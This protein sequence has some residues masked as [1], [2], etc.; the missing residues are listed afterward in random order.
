MTTLLSS[1][2]DVGTTHDRLW[3]DLVAAVGDADAADV[4]AI[5]RGRPVITAWTAAVVHA[6]DS[7]QY[8]VE[9]TAV[10]VPTSSALHHR[11]YTWAAPSTKVWQQTTRDDRIPSAMRGGR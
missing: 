9:R 8:A 5:R 6:V 7:V 2:A 10:Q 1:F 4:T 11:T 3:R